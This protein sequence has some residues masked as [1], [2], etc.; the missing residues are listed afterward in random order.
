MLYIATMPTSE[1]ILNTLSNNQGNN[2]SGFALGIID[3]CFAYLF[4]EAWHNLHKHTLLLTIFYR[5]FV[6]HIHEKAFFS[7]NQFHLHGRAHETP[8]ATFS[9]LVEES[10][11]RNV[12]RIDM[13][14]GAN[15]IDRD[16]VYH[17]DCYGFRKLILSGVRMEYNDQLTHQF[18]HDSFN[19]Y[20]SSTTTMQDS[21]MCSNGNRRF[22]SFSV[23]IYFANITGSFMI[24]LY[25]QLYTSH[26][27]IPEYAPGIYGDIL[28]HSG[29]KI[30]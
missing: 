3:Y 19:V 1:F 7:K 13:R 9:L 8:F 16:S 11:M 26:N 25:A 18:N 21:G 17:V 12:S 15:C 27:S 14:A 4:L 6:A 23:K 29:I 30:M 28:I 20:N 24:Y 22:H 2:P 10:F 5:F